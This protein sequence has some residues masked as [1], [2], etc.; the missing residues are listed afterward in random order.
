GAAEGAGGLWGSISEFLSGLTATLAGK[1]AVG[2]AAF[3]MMAGAGLTAYS[4]LSGGKRASLG[5]PNLGG[6]TDSLKIRRGGHDRIGVEN[7]G[8]I[9]FPGGE[10]AAAAKAPPAPAEKTADAKKPYLEKK[11]TADASKGAWQPQDRLAHNLSGAKLS[12]SFGNGFG[13]HNIFA[14]NSVVPDFAPKALPG[15]AGASP[16]K[17]KLSKASSLGVAG[18]ASARSLGQASSSRALGQLKWAKGMSVAAAGSHSAEQAASGAQSAF[19]QQQTGGGNLITPS[20]YGAVDTP[21]SG[22]AP[23]TTMPTAPGTPTATQGDQPLQN[24][25]SQ[26]GN[27]ANQAMQMKQTGTMLL[28]MGAALIAVGIALMCTMWGAAIGA[29]LIGIGGMLVGMGFMMLNMAQMMAQMAKSM[30]AMVASQVGPYQG[31]VVNYCTDQA[32]NGTPTQDCQPPDSMTHQSSV[33]QNDQQA[34]QQQ[35]TIGTDTPTVTPVKG[36]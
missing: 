15:M 26:I 13:S 36:Q 20:Q 32:L 4:L 8:L 23:D 6:I 10:K 16:A 18:R 7:D 31:Q 27:M 3:L 21:S 24:Q 22:G 11:E 35:K 1:L 34:L 28:M 12:S 19:D 25:M 2:A 29:A 5:L 17:G 33:Q 30:G 9:R 14:G